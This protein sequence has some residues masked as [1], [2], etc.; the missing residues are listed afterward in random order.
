LV[1]T[2]D[3]LQR[4]GFGVSEFA[5]ITNLGRTSVYELIRQGRVRVVKIGRRTIIPRSEIDRLLRDNQPKSEE[6]QG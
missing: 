3:L 4:Q 2:S 5:Y 6:D 1:L